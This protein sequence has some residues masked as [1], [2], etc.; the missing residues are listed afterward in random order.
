MTAHHA[1]GARL[2]NQ[3]ERLGVTLESIAQT[4]KI[5]RSLLAALERADLSRWPRGIYRRAFLRD[6]AAAIGLPAEPLLREVVQLFPEPGQDQPPGEGVRMRLMLLPETRWPVRVRQ[7]LAAALD[8]AAILVAAYGVS[9]LSGGGLWTTMAGAGLSYHAASTV[10]LGQSPG[11]WC[12][13]PSGPFSRMSRSSSIADQ[14][15]ALRHDWL[16]DALTIAA[17]Q[18]R[19]RDSALK[20]SP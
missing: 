9:A 10:A 20:P 1:F 12:L 19:A 16:A 8:S 7:M 6:Y 15:A 2:Q 14:V 5:N 3:R 18:P 4:T 17:L 11:S 13:S